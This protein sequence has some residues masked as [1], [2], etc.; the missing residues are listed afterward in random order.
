MQA[1]AERADYAPGA[2]KENSSRYLPLPPKE[3]WWRMGRIRFVGTSGAIWHWMQVDFLHMCELCIDVA[4]MRQIDWRGRIMMGF[5]YGA[6]SLDVWAW[7]L[8]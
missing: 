4:L 6:L 8:R 3:V 5:F 7:L 2:L 1:G